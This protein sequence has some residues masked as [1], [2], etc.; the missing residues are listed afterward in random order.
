[1]SKVFQFVAKLDLTDPIFSPK[2]YSLNGK[3]G[4]IAEAMV[5]K[6]HMYR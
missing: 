6:V 3:D 5:T 1:M 2:Y 4:N